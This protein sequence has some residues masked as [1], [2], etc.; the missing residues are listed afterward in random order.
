MK[1]TLFKTTSKGRCYAHDHKQVVVLETSFINLMDEQ[2]TLHMN[3]IAH[4][5]K[6]GGAIKIDD[7]LCKVKEDA[8]IVYNEPSAR[9][10]VELVIPPH[11]TR[12]LTTSFHLQDVICNQADLSLADDVG[13]IQLHV[14]QCTRSITWS[15]GTYD[16]LA[17]T[18]VLGQHEIF[19]TCGIEG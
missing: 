16:D 7:L 8:D 9:S 5:L 15:M 17:G 2:L 19:V 18:E 13:A 11:S 14:K 1:K 10:A 6:S 4:L 3:R 12:M